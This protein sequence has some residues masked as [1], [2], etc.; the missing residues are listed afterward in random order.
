MKILYV[1]KDAPDATMAKIMDE[2]RKSHDVSS[3][4]IRANK[5]YAK[6]VDAIEAADKVIAA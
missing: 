5:D 2:H 6:I 1:I 3:I 4:D